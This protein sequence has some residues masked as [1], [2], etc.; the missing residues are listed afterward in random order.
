MF[1]LYLG[2]KGST[3]RVRVYRLGP[4]TSVICVFEPFPGLSESVLPQ[5][6]NHKCS[7]GCQ[8][9]RAGGMPAPQSGVSCAPSFLRGLMAGPQHHILP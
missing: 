1:D 9:D 6:A 3:P 8:A 5:S 7:V 2:Q 4:A